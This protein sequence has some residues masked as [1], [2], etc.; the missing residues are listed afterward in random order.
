[1]MIFERRDAEM[2]EFSTPYRVSV[3]AVGRDEDVLRGERMEKVKEFKYL[4]IFK[5]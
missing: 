1:M 5:C 3:Q 2:V 4:E